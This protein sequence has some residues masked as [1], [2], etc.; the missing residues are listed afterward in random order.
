MAVTAG[1]SPLAPSL[2]PYKASTLHVPG[3][4]LVSPVNKR[5]NRSTW[6]SNSHDGT[7]ARERDLAGLGV[8]LDNLTWLRNL[9]EFGRQ[10]SQLTRKSTP[11]TA[12]WTRTPG[13]AA[14]LSFPGP[15]TSPITT[16]RKPAYASGR[17]Q[18]QPAD[19]AMQDRAHA[20]MSPESMATATANQAQL[21]L[22]LRL[23]IYGFH[24]RSEPCPA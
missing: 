18:S 10:A 17:G 12:P 9:L 6:S 21:V 20:P 22:A 4:S 11:K 1:G 23:M 5:Q 16:G 14:A 15:R 8:D 24:D 3:L 13:W 19:A 7:S 2:S